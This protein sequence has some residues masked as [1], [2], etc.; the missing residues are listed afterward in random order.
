MTHTIN[1]GEWLVGPVDRLVADAAHQMLEGVEVE[2]TVGVLAR[3]GNVLGCYSLNQYQAPNEFTIT[4]VCQRGT[5]RFELH[6]FR[7][8]WM[9][10][11]DGE[12]HDEDN[13]PLQRDVLF[14][15]QANAFL[16]V[17]DGTGRPL[18]TLD[19]GIQTLRVNLAMLASSEQQSWQTID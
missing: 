1:A 12:W 2:D 3:Q 19:E 14:V 5:C 9:T 15:N 11:P 18:C 17:L 7:W 6:K 10:E 8:R 16:D 13:G 4:V